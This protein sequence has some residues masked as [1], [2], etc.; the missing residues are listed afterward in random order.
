MQ[1]SHSVVFPAQIRSRLTDLGDGQDEERSSSTGFNDDRQELGVDGAERAVPRHLGNS[2]VI[3]HLLCLDT[4][5]EDMA[6]LTLPYNAATHRCVDTW[7]QENK[8][9]HKGK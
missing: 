4:L 2:D 3:V 1:I 7:E 6:E 9:G 5:A 8:T